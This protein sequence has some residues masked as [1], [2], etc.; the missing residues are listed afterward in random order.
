MK[1]LAVLFAIG[2]LAQGCASYNY[3]QNVKMVAFSDDVTKGKSVGQVEGQDCTW[4]LLGYKL[5]G[6]PTISK[7]FSNTH[8]QAD[9]M[10]SAGMS[11]T[12]ENT[13]TVRYVN[14]VTSSRTGF[15]AY[16]VGKDCLV[17]KGIGYK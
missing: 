5:G 4:T 17:V 9:F 1:N 3:A 10:Q 8:K 7:A 16:V 15:N 13:N 11:S 2:V 12:H 14:N 6:E